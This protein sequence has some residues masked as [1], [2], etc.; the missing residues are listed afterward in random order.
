MFEYLEL[1]PAE[2]RNQ[3]SLFD[4]DFI[5]HLTKHLD[6]IIKCVEK[7]GT[8][9]CVVAVWSSIGHTGMTEDTD[10]ISLMERLYN[11]WSCY[12]IDAF[13]RYAYRDHATPMRVELLMLSRQHN[14]KEGA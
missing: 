7:H 10:Y 12:S 9:R 6:N 11:G 2:K 8:D 3:I 1:L 5:G 14:K 13:T 4:L